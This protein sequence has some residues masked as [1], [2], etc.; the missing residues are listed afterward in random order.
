MRDPLAITYGVY[1]ALMLRE[2]LAR[3]S[4][5]RFTWF[6]LLAEPVFHVA[7]MLVIF[8]VFRVT[9]IGGT[10]TFLWLMTGMLGFFMFSRTARQV[11]NGINANKSLFA[12]RQVHP[13]DTV[14][15]RGVL[16]AFLMSL[17]AGL[18]LTGAALLGH[19]ALPEDPLAVLLAFSGVWLAG[20]GFGLVA[21]V[22]GELIPE[23]GRII[24]FFLMPLYMISGVIFPLSAVPLPYREWLMYNPVAHGLEAARL[25]FA[26]YYH[27]VPE[28]S[29]S[30]LYGFALVCT[31]LGLALQRR[32][33]LRMVMQ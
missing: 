21:S 16:E 13:I 19:S 27:A 28:L 18:L 2:A 26:P 15:V 1:R 12:Y 4:A 31:F 7:Y 6:W 10:D 33:A 9:T 11:R 25:G 3:V 17:V 8:T 32:F 14:L 5:A 22:A 29:L 20:L 23:L 24:D 30:Y